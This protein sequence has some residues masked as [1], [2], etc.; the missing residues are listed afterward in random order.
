M[1]ARLRALRACEGVV[2][3]RFSAQAMVAVSVRRRPARI[4]TV[5]V[6]NPGLR[7]SIDRLSSLVGDSRRTQCVQ[8][9]LELLLRLGFRL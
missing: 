5:I 3:M 8:S 2:R 6:G 4:L 7:R 1:G 9:C